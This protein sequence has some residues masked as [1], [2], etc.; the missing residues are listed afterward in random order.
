MTCPGPLMSHTDR[1]AGRVI[2]LDP[3]TKAVQ[4]AGGG[5]SRQQPGA[6]V[7][8]PRTCEQ[9]ACGCREV[10]MLCLWPH[11]RP[12]CAVFAHSL[13]RGGTYIQLGLPLRT[14]CPVYL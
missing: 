6:S 3:G 14:C 1:P 2:S 8:P 4:E 12:T 10:S 13:G 9:A 7:A 11:L 5:R